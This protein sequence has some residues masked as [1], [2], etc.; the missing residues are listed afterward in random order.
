MA[1]DLLR[2]THLPPALF[3]TLAL[4]VLVAVTVAV[5]FIM[6]RLVHRWA[7]KLDPS[8]GEIA[9]EVL[10]AF[11]LPILVLGALY[12][13]VNLL[14]LP[15]RYRHYVSEAVLALLIGILFYAISRMV[16]L[17]LR[18]ATVRDPA[19]VRI[20]EPA[21]FLIRV[22][23]AFLAL[24]IILENLG[25][26]LTAVWTT[27]GVGGVAV[28]LALQSTIGNFFAGINLLA[29]RP[30]STGDRVKLASG[31]E[32]KV[33]RIGW[34][35]TQLRTDSDDVV[36]VPNSVM[37]TSVFANR[38]LP[39]VNEPHAT[40]S[41]PVKVSYRSDPDEVENTLLDAVKE[42]AAHSDGLLLDPTPRVL[43]TSEVGNAWME[44]SLVIRVT[45]SADQQK[46]KHELRKR[47]LQ[48]YQNGQIQLPSSG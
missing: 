21:A 26:S 37:M 43:L 13:A 14:A 40:I 19:L 33:I 2:I 4:I 1:R 22:T 25:V 28:G 38:S 39:S 7:R 16:V 41:I 8:R 17:V 34:Y 5:G 29:S 20:T 24:I 48:R 46:I 35:A 45:E 44:F 32:G 11:I 9:R 6:H 23:L 36:F 12:A 42:G 47:I 18:R 15:G 31:Q 27:L 3:Y 10:E 30:F